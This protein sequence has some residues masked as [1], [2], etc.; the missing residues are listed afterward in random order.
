MNDKPAS[1]SPE[2]VTSKGIGSSALLGS[3]F[4]LSEVDERTDQYFTLGM[5]R[6]LE[7]VIAGVDKFGVELCQV[8]MEGRESACL[9]VHEYRFGFYG[10]G[11]PVWTRK[12]VYDYEREHGDRWQISEVPNASSEPMPAASKSISKTP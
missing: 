11:K 8:A 2:V 4:E 6:T 1:E 9:E 3:V 5:F 10:R 7:D 12:W